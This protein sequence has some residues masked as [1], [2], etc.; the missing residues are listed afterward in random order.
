M[1]RLAWI[2]LHR[3][4]LDAA[5]ADYWAISN[6]PDVI[7]ARPLAVELSAWVVAFE[8][9]QQVTEV[10]PG[11]EF[12]DQFDVSFDPIV[13]ADHWF[14]RQGQSLVDVDRIERVGDSARY[15]P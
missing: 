1:P 12:P 10:G 2:R 4:R 8:D 7:S 14:M 6:V 13:F 11:A 15:T 5:K 9:G 3:D